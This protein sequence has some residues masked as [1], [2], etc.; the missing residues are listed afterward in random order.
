MNCSESK[1]L[2]KNASK[3]QNFLTASTPLIHNVSYK[4][5]F[6]SRKQCFSNLTPHLTPPEHLNIGCVDPKSIC[7]CNSVL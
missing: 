4:F 5:L 7:V 2:T 3:L 6:E 1:N